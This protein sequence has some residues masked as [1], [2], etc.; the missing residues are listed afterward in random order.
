[1]LDAKTSV[2]KNGIGSIS[3]FFAIAKVI[4]KIKITVVTLSKKALTTAV[5]T[6]RATKIRTGCPFVAFINS[7]AR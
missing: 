7:F 6:P 5:N 3:N 4:G 1:M 2:S